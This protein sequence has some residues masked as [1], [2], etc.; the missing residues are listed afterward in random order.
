MV[1]SMTATRNQRRTA[2]SKIIAGAVAGAILISAVIIAVTKRH[3]SAETPAAK[4][5]DNIRV[6]YMPARDGN[7][8]AIQVTYFSPTSKEAMRAGVVSALQKCADMTHPSQPVVGS[9]L[10]APGDWLHIM[11]VFDP[12]T[13]RISDFDEWEA[14]QKQTPSTRSAAED[15]SRLLDRP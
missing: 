1:Q 12:A 15:L 5:E 4:I 11:L 14:H 9:A 13:G 10:N 8:P 3:R 2:P 7:P 6:D